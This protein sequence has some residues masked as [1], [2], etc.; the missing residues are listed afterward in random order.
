[1]Y[2]V[3]KIGLSRETP[4]IRPIIIKETKS[5]SL[6]FSYKIVSFGEDMTFHAFMIFHCSFYAQNIKNI[7]RKDFRIFRISCRVTQS[8]SSCHKLCITDISSTY[9]KTLYVALLH[10]GNFF[11]KNIG[12]SGVMHWRFLKNFPATYKILQKFWWNMQKYQKFSWNMQN[13]S[14]IF[15][16][17]AKSWKKLFMQHQ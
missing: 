6:S 16:Q 10:A 12:N 4:L 17:H 15:I 13:F 5:E 14:K 9:M 2:W 11:Q 8:E 1:M 3:A 7:P